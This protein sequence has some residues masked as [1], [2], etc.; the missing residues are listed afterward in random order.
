MN[1][2]FLL[3]LI[4]ILFSL[5]LAPQLTYGQDGETPTPT[6]NFTSTPD[7]TPTPTIPPPPQGDGN[8]EVVRI[9]PILPYGVRFFVTVDVPPAE[10]RAVTLTFEQI[11]GDEVLFT[12][13]HRLSLSNSLFIDFGD[14]AEYEYVWRFL[15]NEQI[16]L[17]ETLNY[18][19]QVTTADGTVS[20]FGTTE[21]LAPQ[22]F[23]EWQDAISENVEIYWYQENIQGGYLAF[24]LEKPYALLQEHIGLQYPFRFVIYDTQDLLDNPLCQEVSIP[25]E[26]DNPPRIE[27]RLIDLNEQYPCESDGMTKLYQRF[28]FTPV[29]I[30]TSAFRYVEDSLV[31]TIVDQIYTER[32]GTAQ[33]PEWYRFGLQRLYNTVS[34]ANALDIAIIGSQSDQLL[35]LDQM[36]RPPDPNFSL[37]QNNLWEAQAYLLTLYLAEFL[38]ADAPFNIALAINS[39]TGFTQALQ[40]FTEES[41][42]LIYRRWVSW[43]NTQNAQ[44]AVAWNPYLETTPTL[45]L[46]PTPTPT[47]PTPTPTFTITPSLTPTA[48][49]TPIQRVF[50]S[51]PT[52][53]TPSR[54]TPNTSTPLPPNSLNRPTSAP[55][56][57]K[58]TTDSADDNG[59][60]GSGLGA[61]IFPTAALIMGLKQRKQKRSKN[62]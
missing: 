41:I 51:V 18:R 43:L 59:L 49:N 35:R 11:R 3:A 62:R 16:Y 9:R 22:G 10:V 13:T 48:G 15:P 20:E 24:Q 38:G 54:V 42:T 17:F 44:R 56:S 28:G 12:R 25:I 6:P 1:R 29:A 21:I 40:Q 26:G 2:I 32:W 57:G 45:T 50:T 58:T 61:L 8:I 7:F 36:E 23:G 4:T 30:E 60:C 52:P 33:V 14:R 47:I 46:T 53:F 39:Q 27:L 55:P 31:N 5:T 37:A 19:F 34:E